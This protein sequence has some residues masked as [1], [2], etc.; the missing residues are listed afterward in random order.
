M[1]AD[2]QGFHQGQLVK[3][4]LAGRMQLAGGQHEPLAKPTVH[5]HAQD[6]QLLAAIAVAAPARITALAIHVGLHRTALAGN[7]VRHARPDCQH[8]HAQLVTRN[9][10][11]REERHLAQVTRIVGAANAHA[12]HSNQRLLR[13]GRGRFLE[14]NGTKLLRLLEL[15]CFHQT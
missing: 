11:I 2:R 14:L 7:H 6:F 3:G 9:P 10:W 4:K 8:F 5:H 12:M 1:A 15:Q 13:P